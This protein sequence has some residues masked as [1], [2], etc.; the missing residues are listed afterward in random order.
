MSQDMNLGRQIGS[1]VLKVFFKRRGRISA[2]VHLP[3]VLWFE[4]DV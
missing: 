3:L 1:F 2:V 4:A